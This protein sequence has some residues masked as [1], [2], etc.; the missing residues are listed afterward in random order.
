MKTVSILDHGAR[1]DGS[2]CT[3][4]IQSA[5]DECFLQG[6]GTVEIP[7]GTYLTGGI[8]LRSNVTLH[9]LENAVLLGTR[10][11]V[12]YFAWLHDSV[13]PLATEDV[14]EDLDS[15]RL[16]NYR[17]LGRRWTNGLIRAIDAENIA[18]I[19]EKGSTIDGNDCFDPLG[20]E[21]YR[22]PHAISFYRCQNI[23]L[24]GYTV[25]RS[26]N[27]AH[28][29]WQGSQIYIEQVQVLAG[30]DGVH[31][32]R[33]DN[34]VIRN[35]QFYTGDDSI[36]GFSNLNVLVEN[37]EV[38]S[39][40]SGFRFAGTNVLISHCHIFAP[41]RYAF[42]GSMSLEEKQK[43]APSH[44]SG[45]RTNMVSA[46]T[47]Y[48][49]FSVDI[50]YQPGN[51]VIADSVIDGADKLF[52]YNR[53]GNE[54]WQTNRPLDNIRFERVVATNLAQPSILYGEADYPLTA[55][56]H[57]VQMTLRPG[58]EHTPLFRVCNYK[59]ISLNHLSVQGDKDVPL[60]QSWSDGNIQ[61]ES[62]S[63]NPPRT[64]LL[65]QMTCPFTVNCI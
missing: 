40:C 3:L 8:R 36:A 1:A 17:F 35:C 9:L 28:N 24:R 51:I 23:H 45:V 11:P 18:I 38:N 32:T 30:H 49:D 16:P 50:P 52:H 29:I 62:L 21:Q 22:G 63:C 19:G 5:I 37:C 46:F 42:R 13:E 44:T 27:W 7:G 47:Y 4:A 55:E 26:A 20:E 12:D 34:V 31:V 14:A 60:I 41:C 64:S 43:G 33:C 57:D 61:V 15:N 48:S 39:A 6:G 59:N 10:D 54:R 56:F 65:E 2:V 58:S 53:S 25:Q